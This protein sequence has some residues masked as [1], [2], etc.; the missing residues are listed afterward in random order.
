[1]KKL[2]LILF[3]F[4]FSLSIKAQND[5]LEA[6]LLSGTDD[7]NKLINAYMNPAMKGL[8][9]GMNNGWY[10]TAKPHKKLGFDLSIG[11]NASKIPSSDEVFK[12]SELGLSVT[13]PSNNEING[14][15]VAGENSQETLM[16]VST[17]VYVPGIGEKTVSTS[18]TMPGGIKDDLP[19]SAVPTPSIQLG[20]GLPHKMDVMIRLVP[21]VGSEDLKG[22]LVGIGLKKEITSWFGPL[23]KLPLHISLLA[24]YTNMNIEYDIQNDSSL[25]GS[26]QSAEFKLNSYNIEAITSLNFPIINIYGG[27]GY[28]S[29]SATLKMLG[30]YDLTYETSLPVPQNE[31][32]IPIVDPI[33][34][35][36]N[37]NGIKATIGTRI[38]FGFFKIYGN[39]TLQEYNTVS[40]GIAFNFR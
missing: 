16:D 18:Y 25:E 31:V 29:G 30:A 19:I 12:F 6:I 20:I 35:D 5:G 33:N 15:T 37:A 9:Y 36:F 2:T 21:Q 14:A 8:I 40:A 27:F 23:D 28:S 17:T 24:A 7:A 13:S 4:L 38:S 26:N 32:T 10:H 22:S 39:Y 34:L 11:F 3:S 1:M